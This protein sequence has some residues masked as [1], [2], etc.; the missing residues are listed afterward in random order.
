MTDERQINKSLE[1]LECKGTFVKIV[2]SNNFHFTGEVLEVGEDFL[3]LMDK[4]NQRTTISKRDIIV[5]S[6]VSH[7]N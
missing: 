2:L 3:V 1:F 7:G 6:E 5:C 4:F